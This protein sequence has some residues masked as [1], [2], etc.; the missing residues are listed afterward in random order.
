MNNEQSNNPL[1]NREESSSPQLNLQPSTN[2][3]PNI[4]P[5]TSSD[6]NIQP[7]TSSQLDFEL[8]KS[9]INTLGKVVTSQSLPEIEVFQH[10][11]FNFLTNSIKLEEGEKARHTDRFRLRTTFNVDLTGHDL[12]EQISSIII[13]SGYWKFFDKEGVAWPTILGP[14]HYPRI[15]DNGIDNDKI[16]RFECVAF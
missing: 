11:N 4:Q 9:E 7:P 2:S 15:K 13:Y 12:Y 10:I 1:P 14:G 5:P 3:D 8:P 6:P 16:G